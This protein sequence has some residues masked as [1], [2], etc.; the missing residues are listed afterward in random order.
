M[1]SPELQAPSS[2]KC[3]AE[4]AY[5]SCSSK[6]RDRNAS[7][8]LAACPPPAAICRPAGGCSHQLLLGNSSIPGST[9]AGIGKQTPKETR[10]GLVLKAGPESPGQLPS[11]PLSL[12]QDQVGS[13]IPTPC[14]S[15]CLLGRKRRRCRKRPGHVIRRQSRGRSGRPGPCRSVGLAGRLPPRISAAF[16]SPWRP[17]CPCLLCSGNPFELKRA[18]GGQRVMSPGPSQF[19]IEAS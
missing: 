15:P 12:G 19:D 8:P 14:R 7:C 1:P 11:Q 18:D 4:E 9:R 5:Q 13:S 10:V 16:P 17:R 3:P 2:W 6:P